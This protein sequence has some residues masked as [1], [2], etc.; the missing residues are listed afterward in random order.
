[1][2][3]TF[4]GTRGSVPSPG[5]KTVRYGGNTT[6]IELRTD[7]NKLI[8][9][10]GGTGLRVFGDACLARKE[11]LD[12]SILL[13]HTHWDHICGFPFFVPAY[14]PGNAFTF[15]GPVHYEQSLKD[16]M[17]GHT[18][19]AYFPVRVEDMAANIQYVDL[20]EGTFEEAGLK[21]VTRYLN[22]PVLCLGYRFESPR[23]KIFCFGTDTEP[24]YNV[25]GSEGDPDAEN[26]A[27]D[28]NTRIVDF[29]RDADLCVWD[30]QYTPDEYKMKQGWGHTSTVQCMEMG[31]KANVKHFCYTH[32]DPNRT[33]DQLDKILED[34]RQYLKE[35]GSSMKIG[36]ATEGVTIEL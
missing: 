13:S 10:D 23:G 21:V 34:S 9:L 15:K 33:D 17:V 7:E 6:C 25:F 11:K 20:K 24:F 3:I 1:M 14:I 28:L 35:R 5:P 16:V 22:H 29:V 30:G 32:H 26:I 8:V 31:I 4:W 18:Q 27:E 19:Y 12:C 2:K 36:A